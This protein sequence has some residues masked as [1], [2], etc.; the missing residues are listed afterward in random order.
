MVSVAHGLLQPPQL[1]LDNASEWPAWIQTFHD[2]HYASEEAQVRA[3]RNI[4]STFNLSEDDAKKFDVV[5]KRFDEYFVKDRNLVFTVQSRT[6]ISD[7]GYKV[8]NRPTSARRKKFCELH[9]CK[10]TCGVLTNDIQN[11]NATL[12]DVEKAAMTWFRHAAERLA[13]QQK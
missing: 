12:K 11:P 2:Y 9:L 4:F 5:R 6:R 8:T 3:L 13:A 7:R 1:D 10:L